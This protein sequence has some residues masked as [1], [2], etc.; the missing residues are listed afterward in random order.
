MSVVAG[1]EYKNKELSSR[2]ED[3]RGLMAFHWLSDTFF[4]TLWWNKNPPLLSWGGPEGFKIED[5]E[6]K[7]TLLEICLFFLLIQLPRKLL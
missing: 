1:W 5:P 4:P 3:E 6:L 2:K 7:L